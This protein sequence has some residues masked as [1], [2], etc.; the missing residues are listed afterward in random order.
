MLLLVALIPAV[1]FLR[2][3]FTY[4][5]NYF[6]QWVAVR[7]ITDL[8]V[9]LFTHLMNLSSGFFSG[10]NTGELMSRTMSDTASLQIHLSAIP[11][12]PS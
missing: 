9:K 1:M 7:A 3:L 4:L 8:R 10:T 12:R 2:G 11:W 5:N 6:L